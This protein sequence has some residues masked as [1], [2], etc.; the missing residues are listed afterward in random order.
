MAEDTG[1]QVKVTPRGKAAFDLGSAKPVE[2]EVKGDAEF[3]LSSAKP[4]GPASSE[5]VTRQ[6]GA[7]GRKAAAHVASVSKQM[8]PDV[9]YSGDASAGL[10]AEYGFM[11]TPE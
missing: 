7:L 4:V 2:P 9:D 6:A 10:R 3:D 8:D 11:D 1:F 5:I